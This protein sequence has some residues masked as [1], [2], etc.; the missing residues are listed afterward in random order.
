[1]DTV[2]SD[3]QIFCNQGAQRVKIMELFKRGGEELTRREVG[4]F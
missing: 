1:M 4:L 3:P 2:T